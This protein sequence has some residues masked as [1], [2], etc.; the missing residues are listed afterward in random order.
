MST[1]DCWCSPPEIA[2]PVEE[3][4]EGPVDVDPCSNDRSIIRART[5]Y[6]VGGLILPWRRRGRRSRGTV[7]ENDPYSK[8]DLWTAKMLAEIACGNVEEIIRL[9]M[10]ACSTRWWADMCNKPERNPRILA[11]RRLAFLDPF[12][13]K[14]GQKRMTCRF[15]PA[16]TYIGPRPERFDRI[17]AHLTRWSTWGRS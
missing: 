8:A 16:L 9:S 1:S 11:L 14:R 6:E 17:F 13:E 12:A 7:Y 5:A 15:E 10:F 2:D 3:F 4:F